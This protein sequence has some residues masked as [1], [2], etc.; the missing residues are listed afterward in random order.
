MSTLTAYREHGAIYLGFTTLPC[1]T[2]AMTSLAVG[3][4]VL[5]KATLVNRIG[6]E[7][8]SRRH[9][10]HLAR[11]KALEH[12]ETTGKALFGSLW[13]GEKSDWQALENYIIWVLEFRRLCVE[14]GLRE[15]A[16]DFRDK[17]RPVRVVF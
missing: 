3:W 7:H 16:E 13:A 9:S 11:R 2:L 12:E 4:S 10:Q 5:I 6:P 15:Q 17:P 1:L 8:S 14:H